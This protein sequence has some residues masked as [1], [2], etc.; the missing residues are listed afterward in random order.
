MHAHVTCA[1][2]P[3]YTHA[4]ARAGS[5]LCSAGHEHAALNRRFALQ[6]AES[7]RAALRVRLERARRCP[8][9]IDAP[10]DPSFERMVERIMRD[11]TV[12]RL[13]KQRE[14]LRRQLGEAQARLDAATVHD[15]ICA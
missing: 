15:G 13:L 6:K 5:R 2:F 12:A 9:A 7:E 4:H 3:T 1:H 14:E 8:K 11:K 10:S